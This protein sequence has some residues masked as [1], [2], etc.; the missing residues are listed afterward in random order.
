MA[1][2]LPVHVPPA[3][4]AVFAMR[5]G[6]AGSAG[7]CGLLLSKGGRRAQAGGRCLGGGVGPMLLA[8]VTEGSRYIE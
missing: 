5:T 7:W 3:S 8:A 6:P 2:P 4:A 1:L